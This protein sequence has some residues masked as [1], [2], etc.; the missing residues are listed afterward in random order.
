MDLCM[1]VCLT[2]RSCDVSIVGAPVL[3]S[4]SLAVLSVEA[5]A[6]RPL[7]AEEKDRAQVGLA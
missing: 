5:V 3:I 1:R 4:Q 2:C 6:R 7:T